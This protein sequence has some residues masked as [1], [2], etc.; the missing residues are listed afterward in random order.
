MQDSTE[1]SRLRL[2]ISWRIGATR[3]RSPT[4]RG[5]AGSGQP[6]EP[7][8]TN[9]A[10][11]P[12]RFLYMEVLK[13]TPAPPKKIKHTQAISFILCEKPPGNTPS[14]VKPA[15]ASGYLATRRTCRSC[16]LPNFG[17]AFWGGIWRFG[18]ADQ[19]VWVSKWDMDPKTGPRVSFSL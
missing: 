14:S 9:F 5:R 7:W 13:G 17:T 10:H 15:G 3:T 4:Y 8:R 18:I 11:R 12:E 16:L 2:R 6:F 1:G 19:H